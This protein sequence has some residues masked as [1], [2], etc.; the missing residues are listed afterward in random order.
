[1][2]KRSCIDCGFAI[3][4]RNLCRPHEFECL[5]QERTEPRKF[6]IRHSLIECLQW[7]SDDREKAVRMRGIS[8]RCKKCNLGSLSLE[9]ISSFLIH[10]GTCGGKITWR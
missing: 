3:K 8:Y 2:E 7:K 5:G 9:E 4:S 10:L 6:D 1:M